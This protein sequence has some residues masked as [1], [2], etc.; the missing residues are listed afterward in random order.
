MLYMFKH[1]YRKSVIKLVKKT[2]NPFFFHLI[3][4]HVQ[5]TQCND[6]SISLYVWWHLCLYIHIISKQAFY[7]T[8]HNIY[9][10]QQSSSSCVIPDKRK[11]RK[12]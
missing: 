7:F 5:S 4:F 2:S 1:I 10:A 9:I 11:K 6:Y 3:H 8:V 12:E